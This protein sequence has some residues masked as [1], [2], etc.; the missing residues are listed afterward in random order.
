MGRPKKTDLQEQLKAAKRSDK[1]IFRCSRCGKEYVNPVGRFYKNSNSEV[2]D[3]NE[4]YC[5]ICKSCTEEM[6]KNYVLEYK[7]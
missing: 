6:F 7:S 3:A 1:H 4:G 2:F 5:T